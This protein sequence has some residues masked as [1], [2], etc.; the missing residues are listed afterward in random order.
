M[1]KI[2]FEKAYDYVDWCF[3]EH[4]L[5]RKRFSPKWRSWMRGCLSST[6]F[7]ILVNGS[8]KGWVKEYKGLRQGD[9]HSPFLFT[10]VVD[11]LS[12]LIFK[13]EERFV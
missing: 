9:P 11:V 12:R 3:L 13:A 10:L 1:F 6:H 4:V 2:D 7:A 5:E 8:T